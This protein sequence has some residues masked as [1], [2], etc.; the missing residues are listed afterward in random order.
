MYGIL[1]YIYHTN[2]LNVGK[3]ASPM[4]GMGKEFLGQFFRQQTN[5]PFPPSFF[6]RTELQDL[7][8]CRLADDGSGA[9]SWKVNGKEAEV[10]E[11]KQGCSEQTTQY[12][13]IRSI[14]I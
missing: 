12:I 5:F 8:E 3:Y 11:T 4:D 6:D 1:T 2:Q 13:D 9:V 14:H 7:V 10:G